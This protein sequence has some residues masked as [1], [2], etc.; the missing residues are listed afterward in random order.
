MYVCKFV[1]VE[2]IH[3]AIF[4]P[5]SRHFAFTCLHDTPV[6]NKNTA[7]D[8]LIT[9]LNHNLVLS[10]SVKLECNVCI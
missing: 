5:V 9:R 8:I 4:K 10:N 6:I 1:T 7:V 2:R 3:K